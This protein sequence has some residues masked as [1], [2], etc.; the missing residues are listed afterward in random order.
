MHESIFSP[1]TQVDSSNKREYGGTGLGLA[2]VKQFVEMHSGNIWL[3]SNEGEG[4]TF[5]FT[6]EDL[7]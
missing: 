1:F 2:L 5:V 4:S 6:I 7:N 3:E